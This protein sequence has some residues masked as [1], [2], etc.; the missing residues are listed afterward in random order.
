MSVKPAK[1]WMRKLSG[2]F[3]C[4]CSTECFYVS[5]L[6]SG[7]CEEEG[8]YRSVKWKTVIG[9]S[10]ASPLTPIIAALTGVLQD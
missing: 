1:G 4:G 3:V 2:V 9:H 10:D 5:M 8:Y 7:R 6:A